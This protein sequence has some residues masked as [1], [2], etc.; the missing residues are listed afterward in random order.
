VGEHRPGAGAAS[1]A[2]CQ[3]GAGLLGA[4]KGPFVLDVGVLGVPIR[5]RVNPTTQ[6]C[7]QVSFTGPSHLVRAVTPPVNALN[8]AL[9]I[10]QR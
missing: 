6:V 3:R 2:L 5:S 8:L 10:R 7:E 9:A 1:G 4:C